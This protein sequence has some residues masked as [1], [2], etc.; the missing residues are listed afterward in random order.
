MYNYLLFVPQQQLEKPNKLGVAYYQAMCKHSTN[1]TEICN[2]NRAENQRVREETEM[3][4]KKLL[5]S[6][7]TYMHGM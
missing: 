5:L 2:I 3:P 1:K 4:V 7:A 6:K